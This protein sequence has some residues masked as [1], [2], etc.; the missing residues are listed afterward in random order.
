[1]PER[2]AE[3][4]EFQCLRQEIDGRTPLAYGLVA[5]EIAALGASIAVVDKV[6][7]TL[8]GAAI[9][10]IFLWLFWMDHASQSP[11]DRSMH[12]AGTC[13]AN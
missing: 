13:P 9:I 1:M 4:V 8:L 10:P 7:D 6:S 3:L 12:R 5:L 2:E 11:Q